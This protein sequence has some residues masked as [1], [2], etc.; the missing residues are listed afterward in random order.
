MSISEKLMEDLIADYPHEFIEEGLSLI[1]RQSVY[2]GRRIDLLFRDK[3]NRLLIVEIKRGTLTREDIG[4]IHEYYG[5][6]KNERPRENLE[7][8]FIANV[9]PPER[10]RLLED[11]GVNF[12][13]ISEDRFLKIMETYH[14]EIDLDE[15]KTSSLRTE[16]ASSNKIGMLFTSINTDIPEEYK[17]YL[18]EGNKELCWS[19]NN[20]IDKNNYPSLPNLIG[21]IN[22]KG[23][24]IQYKCLITDI[25]RYDKS[26]A[27]K[28]PAT[29]REENLRDN[30]KFTNSIVM[31]KIVNFSY[32]WRELNKVKDGKR[33]KRR[34]DIFLCFYLKI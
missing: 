29:F 30:A 15:T 26:H 5:I 33:S 22:I 27:N 14:K 9:I 12:K 17:K 21:L 6:I 28:K 25:M 1:E 18:Q 7:L 19:I 2:C 3:F 4:Q 11:M 34:V 8:M 20:D 23:K 13:E 31:K 32:D 10:K 24:G 16:I